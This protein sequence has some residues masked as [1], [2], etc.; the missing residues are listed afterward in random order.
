MPIPPFG[1]PPT[2]DATSTVKGKIR[3][4]GDLAGTATSP[5]L[6]AIVAGATVGSSTLIPVVTYDTKG[7]ITGTTTAAVTTG[8]QRTFAFWIG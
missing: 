6:T 7:R 1:S 3:L 2:P 5:V 4:A 8:K